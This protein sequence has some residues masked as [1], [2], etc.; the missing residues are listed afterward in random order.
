MVLL[1]FSFYVLLLSV[2]LSRIPA[3]AAT[4]CDKKGHDSED[5]IESANSPDCFWSLNAAGWLTVD[6]K[7][8]ETADGTVTMIAVYI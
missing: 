6:E 2:A 5:G 1:N 7:S 8:Y 3:A 4:D